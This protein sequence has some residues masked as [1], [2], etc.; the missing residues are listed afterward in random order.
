MNE[1]IVKA[2]V[3]EELE[4]FK[5]QLESALATS[6]RKALDTVTTEYEDRLRSLEEDQARIL[7]H[8]GL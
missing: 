2:L 8:L 7:R 5:K 1:A 3:D 6:M 4:A